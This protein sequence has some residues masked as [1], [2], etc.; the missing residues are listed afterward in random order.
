MT[1]TPRVPGR[2]TLVA[3]A[4]ACT[5]TATVQ[6]QPAR[7]EPTT[8]AEVQAELDRLYHD[9][10]VATDKYNAA[11]EKVTAQQKSVNRLT[12]QIDA[13]EKKLTQLTSLAGSAARAQYRG[14][15]LPA[16]AQFLLSPDPALALDTA[17]MTRQAQLTTQNV[18]TA[19]T[20]TREELTTR[21]ADASDQLRRLTESRKAKAAERKTIEKRIDDA[22]QLEALLSAQQ[23]RDLEALDRKTAGDSQDKWEST[24]I[25]KKVGTEASAAG[26]KAIAFATSQIGKPYVWGAQGPNSFDCSGLTSQAWLAAGIPIPRTSQEQWRQLKHVPVESMRPGDLIIYFSGAT[27]VALYIGDG[28]IIHAPRP[29]R[30]VTVAPAGSMAILGVVRP[31]A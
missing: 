5:V 30:W 19:L 31:D 7:A 20:E 1:R 26:R 18:L 14:G 2:R 24:G 3:V 23:R 29:G 6:Q 13:A 16:E 12:T 25:L 22:R 15:G 21:K 8:L 11:N 27:H 28:Q 9:A 10:E 4:L 17:A